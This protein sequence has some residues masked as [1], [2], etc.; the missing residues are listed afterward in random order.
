MTT[1]EQTLPHWDV[2][3]IYPSLES[4]EFTAAFQQMITG[5]AELEHLCDE[6]GIA[7][8]DQILIDEVT[9]DTFEQVVARFNAL[10]EHISTLHAYIHSFVT[11][12]SRNTRALAALSELQPQLVRFELIGT[13]LTAWIGSLDVELLLE[14]SELAAAHAYMLHKA[15]ISALHLMSPAEEALAAELG[16]TGSSAWQRLYSS[17]T[18]Q[19]LVPFD[20]QELPMPALRNMAFEPDRDTRRRAYEAEL[21]AWKRNATPIAAAL[22]SIKGEVIA[23]NRRRNWESSLDAALFDNNIDRETLDAMLGAARES[24][25]DFRRYLR[26]KARALGSS[27]LA[28]YDLFAPLGSGRAW[29]FDEG[30]AFIIEHFTAFSPRLG[31]LAER[32]F[33]ERWI[34]AEPRPGKRGGAFCMSVRPGE[35]RILS[36]FTPSFSQVGTLAHELGHAY[37]N[38]NL[39]SRTPLQRSTP[40]TLA[41]TASIFCETIITHAALGIVTPQE[42]LGILDASLQ[43][44]C[45]VVVDITSRFLFEEQLFDGR[46]QRELSIDELCNIMLD[47]QH[48]TYGDGLDPEALHQYMWAAKPHYY[49]SSFYNYPYMFGLLFGLGLYARYQADPASFK[50]SYDDLLASTGLD[51]AAELAS[52]FQIDIHDIGFWRASLDV[53]RAEVTRFEGLVGA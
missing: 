40:M 43:D 10:L 7:Q 46:R 14:Q 52:R 32:A 13:R 42:Q 51:G 4:P 20:G 26:A 16:I 50:A 48:A 11:T 39:A 33:R 31:G 5:L 9:V 27:Q 15:R 45:Q 35:S 17:F 21:A 49:G 41:E 29:S 38:F 25:P 34:D 12:D 44:S 19:I 30:A 22:N 37:H 3:T 8:R 18:S 47:A 1:S 6:R 36:N 2:S 24:F 28:W 23:L 53:V